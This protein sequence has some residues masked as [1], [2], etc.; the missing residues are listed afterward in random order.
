[1]DE[2]ESLS[3]SKWERKYHVVFIPNKYCEARHGQKYF[4]TCSQAR[5]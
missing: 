4:T 3:Y 1:M 2:Y 5:P